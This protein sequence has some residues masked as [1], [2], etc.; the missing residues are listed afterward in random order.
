ML[1]IFSSPPLYTNFIRLPKVSGPTPDYILNDTKLFSFFKDTLEAIDGSPFNAFAAYDQA[2]H[3]HDGA[4]TTNAL[5]IC[6]FT[7]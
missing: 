4:L 1:V 6:N 3:N 2:L 5:A 7:M